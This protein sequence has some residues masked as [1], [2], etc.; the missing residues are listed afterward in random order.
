MAVKSLAFISMTQK[1][2]ERFTLTV[3]FL[4]V[5]DADKFHLTGTVT[6]RLYFRY[7]L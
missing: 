6:Y 5:R 3:V 2:I 1:V 4:K 7:L